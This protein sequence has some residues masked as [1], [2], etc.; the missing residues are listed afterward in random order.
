M[1]RIFLPVL[2]LLLANR[3]DAQKEIGNNVL[4][5]TAII[6]LKITKQRDSYNILVK[7]ITV[8]NDEKQRTVRKPENANNNGLVALVLDKGNAV[9]DSLIINEPLVTRYEYP[10]EDGTI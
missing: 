10:N 1:T 9:I 6:K 2:C 7:D 4:T 5:K 8:V 3:T